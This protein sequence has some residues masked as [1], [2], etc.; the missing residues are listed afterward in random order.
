MVVTRD[1]WVASVVA[2][3]LLGLKVVSLGWLMQLGLPIPQVRRRQRSRQYADPMSRADASRVAIV[4][5]YFNPLHVGHL[6]M[7]DGRPGAR[8]LPRRDRQQRRAAAGARS[9]PIVQTVDDRMEIVRALRDVD[10]VIVSVDR[11][12][13]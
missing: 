6:R 10:E 4:S 11:D 5:G 3:C 2:L 8:G 1:P 7:I 13:R 9:A 12:T